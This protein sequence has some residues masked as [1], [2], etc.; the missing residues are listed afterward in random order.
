MATLWLYKSDMQNL[1]RTPFTRALSY[2]VQMREREFQFGLAA[3][4]G[5]NQ[6]LPR[7]NQLLNFTPD[8]ETERRRRDDLAFLKR[9]KKIGVSAIL[10]QGKMG[11]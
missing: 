2:M 8:E 7:F 11:K 4:A 9:F 5:G 3:L 1:A 10:K 6:L